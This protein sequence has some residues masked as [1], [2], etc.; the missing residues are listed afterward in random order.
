M[1]NNNNA[2]DD[3]LVSSVLAGAIA[4]H[5]VEESFQVPYY[6]QTMMMHGGY[7]I[8]TVSEVLLDSLPIFAVLPL[9]VYLTRQYKMIWIRDTLTVVSLLHPFMDHV[10]LTFQWGK[11]RPGSLTALGMVFPLG[12]W[13]TAVQ[14][15]SV[16]S[17]RR[18][19]ITDISILGYGLGLAISIL[20]YVAA[21]VEIR[22]MMVP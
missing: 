10:F 20:L 8:N 2:N 6:Q 18:R 19:R 4:L 16:R 5:T 12:I 7:P 11:R 21:D 15:S 1:G 14:I 17:R 3:V 9:S 13:S 22:A